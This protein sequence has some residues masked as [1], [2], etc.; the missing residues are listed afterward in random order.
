MSIQKQ[1][2]VRDYAIKIY[3]GDG[4]ADGSIGDPGSRFQWVGYGIK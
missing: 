3:L 4:L 2:F 1:R